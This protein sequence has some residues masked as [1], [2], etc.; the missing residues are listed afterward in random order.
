MS[1]SDRKYLLIPVRREDYK[2]VDQLAEQLAQGREI[3][4]N[5]EKPHAEVIQGVKEERIREWTS[6][7]KKSLLPRLWHRRFLLPIDRVFH[8]VIMCECS[9]HKLC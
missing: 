8:W 7:T 3:L 6:C 2:S 1:V 5:P 9:N 4:E